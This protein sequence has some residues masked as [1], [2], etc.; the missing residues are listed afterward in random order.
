MNNN[1][2]FS[3]KITVLKINVLFFHNYLTKQSRDV[4]GGLVED[5]VELSVGLVHLVSFQ[6]AETGSSQQMVLND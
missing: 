6:Q 3:T 4:V 1:H 2:Y 5:E